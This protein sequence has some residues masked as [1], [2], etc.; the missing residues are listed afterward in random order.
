MSF[1]WFPSEKLLPLGLSH[2]HIAGLYNCDQLAKEAVFV[3]QKVT[4]ILNS[5][6]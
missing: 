3:L 2:F 6:K 4:L 1:D 5:T